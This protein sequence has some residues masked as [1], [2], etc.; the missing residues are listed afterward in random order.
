MSNKMNI[1]R[2]FMRNGKGF[3]QTHE[4]RGQIALCYM[5]DKNTAWAMSNYH[6]IDLAPNSI[7]K[8][9]K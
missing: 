2:K 9:R 4:V 8:W 5:T 1:V 7:L 6:P 3:F